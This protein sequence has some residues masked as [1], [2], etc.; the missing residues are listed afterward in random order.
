LATEKAEA[1]RLS[2]LWGAL[3]LSGLAPGLDGCS[4]CSKS[5][6]FGPG[7]LSPYTGGALCA[8]CAR[9]KGGTAL[10]AGSWEVLRRAAAGQPQA[11]VPPRAEEALLDWLAFH[12]GHPLRTAYLTERLK[13]GMA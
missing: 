13:G 3:G 4:Q 12:L 11:L 1:I 2:V 10:D 6:P 9:G 8:D 7:V 5:A